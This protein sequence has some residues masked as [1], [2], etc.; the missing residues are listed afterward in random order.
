MANENP[1][2]I[3]MK[4]VGLLTHE[5]KQAGY[6]VSQEEDF[7]WLWQ[8]NKDT[9]HPRIVGIFLYDIVPVKQIREFCEKDREEHY[10]S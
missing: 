3:K 4:Y 10:E 9:G 1:T 5:Q 8:S 6:F 2:A 7:I